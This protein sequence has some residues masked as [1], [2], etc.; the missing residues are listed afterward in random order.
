MRQ[1]T[2]PPTENG[3]PLRPRLPPYIES[4][5][6]PAP[7]PVTQYYQT[8]ANNFVVQVGN[9]NGN[10]RNF[11]DVRAAEL[12]GVPVVE[13]R[14][15]QITEM[16]ENNN[17]N[18]DMVADGTNFTTLDHPQAVTENFNVDVNVEGLG[19]VNVPAWELLVPPRLCS[20]DSGTSYVY[21]H[22]NM[23]D[24]FGTGVDQME[25]F[26]LSPSNKFDNINLS[27]FE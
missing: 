27:M 5:V 13:D 4:E 18:V 14:R 24:V 15:C 10:P 3:I 16:V 19:T 21:D 23:D 11:Q 25:H 7:N 20:S 8:T 9:M 17:V 6:V 1:V 26:G 2:H 22:P 12:F